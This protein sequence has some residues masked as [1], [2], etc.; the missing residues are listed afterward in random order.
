MNFVSWEIDYSL[1]GKSPFSILKDAVMALGSN[2]RA[3][4]QYLYSIVLSNDSSVC[5]RKIYPF[6]K[7]SGVVPVSRLKYLLKKLGLGKCSASAISVIVL[8][9]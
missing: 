6:R 7:V 8:L 4:K 1:W 2:E 5:F 9:P 3:K